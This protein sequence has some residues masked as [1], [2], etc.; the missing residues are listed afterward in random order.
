MLTSP[1]P[2]LVQSISYRWENLIDDSA[3]AEDARACAVTWQTGVWTE[4][5]EVLHFITIIYYLGVFCTLR[6]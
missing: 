6:E 5:L 3:R 1:S 2:D 4:V